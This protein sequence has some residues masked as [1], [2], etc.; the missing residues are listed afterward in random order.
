MAREETAAFRLTAEEMELV[1]IVIKYRFMQQN[2]GGPMKKPTVSEYLRYLVNA[3]L[4][5]AITEIEERRR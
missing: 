2:D 5:R 1:E 3:D 4:T